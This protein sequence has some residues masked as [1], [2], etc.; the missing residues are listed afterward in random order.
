MITHK[1]GHYFWDKILFN[2]HFSSIFFFSFE[3]AQVPEFEL[4]YIS[5]PYFT[6]LIFFWVWQMPKLK[7]AFITYVCLVH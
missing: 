5:T 6:I 1:F 4:F 2:G 3:K 7:V